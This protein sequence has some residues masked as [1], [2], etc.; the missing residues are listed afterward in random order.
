MAHRPASHKTPHVIPII[1]C[2]VQIGETQRR[3]SNLQ[4]N[5]KKEECQIENV[6]SQDEFR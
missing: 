5:S 3:G 6:N 1:L 4:Q 2:E